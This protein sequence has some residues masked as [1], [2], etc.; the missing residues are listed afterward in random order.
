MPACPWLEIAKVTTQVLAFLGAAAFFAYKAITG[1]LIVNVSLSA[2]IERGR[3]TDAMDY[4]AI[5]ATVKKGSHGSLELHDA[6]THV[7]WTG[8]SQ[9]RELIGFE[10]LSFRT[11][12]GLERK[13]IVFA[14][15][16][17]KA[18]LLRLTPEEE[19]TFSA[20]VEV[21]SL[22]ANDSET[23]TSPGITV[24]GGARCLS[25]GS[26]EE[27]EWFPAAG[28]CRHGGA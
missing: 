16:S 27:A 1:Y 10:R 15:V 25:Y 12:Q 21:P 9:E 4:L 6:R 28:P 22:C 19:A 13:R 26:P 17:T 24:E 20:L 14:S 5:A 7:S 18:P 11:E 8:G 23:R 2:K 3:G